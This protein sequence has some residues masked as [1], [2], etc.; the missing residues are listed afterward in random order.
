M[1]RQTILKGPARL[2][3]NGVNVYTLD[4]I[5]AECDLSTT[6]I[7]TSAWGTVDKRFND[8]IWKVGFTPA[9]EWRNLTTLWP[10]ESTLVGTSIFGTS[11]TPLVCESLVD[12]RKLTWPVSAISKMPDL[13]VTTTKTAIGQAEFICLG[14]TPWSGA[15]SLAAYTA[16]TGAPTITDFTG[17]QGIPTNGAAITWINAGLTAFETL[18]G[19]LFQ[20]PMKT[21]PIIVDNHGTVDMLFD[22]VDATAS[23][24]PAGVTETVLLS[25]LVQQGTSAGR[26]KSL[27]AL[28]A[29]FVC[30]ATPIKCTLTKAAV[31]MAEMKWGAVP[32]IGKMTIAGTR[33]WSGENNPFGKLFKLEAV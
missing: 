17:S 16:G 28:G 15:N 23:F 7:V 1:D 18:D 33:D 29:D 13:H 4:D 12:G 26:G 22:G 32:R 8:R 2:T 24:S 25:S 14:T 6:D 11:D 5:V 10:Y 20:F 31:T 30:L 9:G 21:K 19:V 3:R 27:N